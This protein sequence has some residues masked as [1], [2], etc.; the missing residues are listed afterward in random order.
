MYRQWCKN[1]KN[2]V[3]FNSTEQPGIR[4]KVAKELFILTD[5]GMYKKHKQN[6]S[7]VYWETNVLINRL[8]QYQ[9]R[10][11]SIR[12]FLWELWG[13]GFDVKE[14]IEIKTDNTEREEEKAKL[15]DLLYG[16]HYM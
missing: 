3:D 2:F 16:T 1:L 5:V 12:K 4:L 13:Y 6:N 8:K 10:Y 9:D 15:I 11:P 14:E 7:P